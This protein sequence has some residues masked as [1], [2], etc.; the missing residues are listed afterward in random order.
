MGFKRLDCCQLILEWWRRRDIKEG[1]FSSWNCF[2][3]KCSFEVTGKLTNFP[4]LSV[5]IKMVLKC[6]LDLMAGNLT[7]MDIFN[8][9]I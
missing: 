5:F 6:R 3:V 1:Y 2:W 9:T 4:N 7:Q 8:L